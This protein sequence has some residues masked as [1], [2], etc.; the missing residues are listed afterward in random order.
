MAIDTSYWADDLDAMIADLPVTARFPA[1][2]GTVF[3]CSATELSQE[4]NLI[5]TGNDTVRAVRIV[6]PVVAFTATTAFKPQ[7]RLQL[8]YPVAST[9]ENYEI[10]GINPS[11][12][13]IAYEVVL[14]SDNRAS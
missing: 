11:P 9:Y 13:F 8:K 5:L 14:K 3:T 4:E 1:S 7:A 10:V 2:T 12:D 6:F